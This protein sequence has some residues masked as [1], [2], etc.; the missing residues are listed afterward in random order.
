MTFLEHSFS[1]RVVLL[2]L[3]M[4]INLLLGGPRWLHHLLHIDAPGNS[5]RRILSFFAERMNRAHRN[6]STRRMRGTILVISAIACSFG[7]GVFVS[8][9]SIQT[10]TWI[11]AELGLLTVLLSIRQSLDLTLD[12]R[13]NLAENHADHA[14]NILQLHVQKDLAPLDQ[15]G[16]ARAA[17][18]Y[19]VHRL[20]SGVISP[21]FWYLLGGLPLALPALAS[22]CLA[23]LAVRP[24]PRYQAFGSFI[25]AIDRIFRA[26]PVA[27]T[28]LLILLVL[29]LVPGAKPKQAKKGLGG[30]APATP[31]IADFRP[32]SLTAFTFGV[33]LLGPCT[34][35]EYPVNYPW[36]GSG[37]ARL[38]AQDVMRM[39]FLFAYASGIVLLLVAAL[40]LLV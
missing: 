22:H 10:R 1:D 3:A 29:P 13:K 12:V 28:V 32:L 2:T 38:G 24:T 15:H 40:S 16:V 35:E 30:D 17:I 26:F 8:L 31:I 36:I 18:E 27:I 20:V 39:Q 23:F 33:A 37:S 5:A 6:E 7:L 34:M 25:A 14:K 4:L 19:L 9:L 11:L 21:A